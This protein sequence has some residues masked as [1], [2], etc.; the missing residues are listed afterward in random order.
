V[1]RRASR[2]RQRPRSS[3]MLSKKKMT[4]PKHTQNQVRHWPGDL[5]SADW[6]CGPCAATYEAA[7]GGTFESAVSSAA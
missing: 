3:G 1:S 7:D 4:P 5:A 6:T 2:V